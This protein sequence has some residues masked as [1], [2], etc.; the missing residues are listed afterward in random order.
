[1][2]VII[3]LI[4]SSHLPSEG[5][6][7]VLPVPITYQCLM[8]ALTEDETILIVI[9]DILAQDIQDTVEDLHTADTTNVLS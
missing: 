4:T 2:S 9:L 6:V 7:Q 8:D 1:M 3:Y 5:K